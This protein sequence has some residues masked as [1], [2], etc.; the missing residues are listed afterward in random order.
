MDTLLNLLIIGLSNGAVIALNAI[1]VTL[2]YGVVR[3]LNFAHGDLF[4]LTTV[5]VTTLITDLLLASWITQAGLA[6]GLVVALAVAIGFGILLNVGVERLAFRPFRGRSRLAPLIATLGFSFILY[7]LALVWRKL[8]PNWIPGEHRSLPGI[9]EVPRGSIPDLVPPLDLLRL[10]GIGGDVSFRLKDALILLL[11][12]AAALLVHAFLQR[13]TTGKTLRAVAQDAQLAQLCGIHLDRAI[14]RVFALGGALAGAAAFGFVLYTT[15]PFGQHGAQSGLLAFTA[16]ILGG[17][18]SPIGA[19]LAGL[20]LGVLA[21]LSDYFLA[22]QWTPVLTESVLILLLLVRPT[23]LTA[24]ESA[25]DLSQAPLRDS[26]AN[27]AGEPSAGWTRWASL[28][29]LALALVYPALDTSL[30]LYK[31]SI[32]SGIV[33]LAVLALGL[34][35]LLGY[36]GLLDLGYAASFGVGAYTA[37]L[38]VNPWGQLAGR[39]PQP[40]DFLVVLLVSGAVAALFGAVNGWLTLRLRSDYLAIVTLAFGHVVYQTVINLNAWTGGI[41][42]ISALPAPQVLTF[43]LQTPTERYYLALALV[44]LTLVVSQR[45]LHSR[46]GR[47]W[48]AIGDDEVAAASSGIDV[49]RVRVLAF[50]IATCVAGMAGALYVGVFSHISP[51]QIDFSMSAMLLA[52][53]VVGGAGSVPGVVLGVLAIASYDRLLLPWLGGVL[54]P[55]RVEQG[56]LSALLDLRELNFLAFG[57]VLYLTVWLRARRLAPPTEKRG[58]R[59]TRLQVG[60]EPVKPR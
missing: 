16:A 45:L 15:H 44:L 5:L 52:M 32:V 9:P 25:E 41:G 4:A 43:A 58:G 53:V 60:P 39:V 10:L 20:V 3:T 46:L 55:Y 49:L 24:Q 1:G 40:V 31:Q 50:I 13:S 23:G 59:S 7:Q 57:L 26:L 8:L 47:A 19:L 34:N 37:A 28:S 27:R 2:V 51:D 21:A 38:L 48:R 56:G 12:C 54:A 42:G 33:I 18:G 6:A 29:L 30:G 17:I 36:A 11:A 35:L 14:S 22:A